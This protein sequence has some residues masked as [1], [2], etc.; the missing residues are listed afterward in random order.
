[1]LKVSGPRSIEFRQVDTVEIY[2]PS[3]R[4]RQDMVTTVLPCP[5]GLVTPTTLLS[6]LD[7]GTGK[8]EQ[9]EWAPFGLTWADGTVRFAR[10]TFPV[11]LAGGQQRQVAIGIGGGDAGTFTIPAAMGISIAYLAI[12]IEIEG[13]TMR[14][15]NPRELYSGNRTRMLRYRQRF[16]ASAGDLRRFWVQ[17]DIQLQ[18]GMRHAKMWLSFGNSYWKTNPANPRDPSEVPTTAFRPT[19]PIRVRVGPAIYT[20]W[21]WDHQAEWGMGRTIAGGMHQIVVADPSVHFDKRRANIPDGCSVVMFGSLHFVNPPFVSNSLEETTYLAEIDQ[22]VVGMCKGWIAA[23]LANPLFD[24]AVPPIPAWFPTEAAAEQ[25]AN[26]VGWAALQDTRTGYM[27]AFSDSHS[28]CNPQPG[29]SGDQHAFGRSLLW[30]EMRTKSVVRLLS[31]RRSEA[32]EAYRA[33]TFRE[34]DT[35]D[36]VTAA[37]HPKAYFWDCRPFQTADD[38]GGKTTPLG[39]DDYT[40]TEQSGTGGAFIYGHDRQHWAMSPT[41]MM[42]MV[43]GDWWM[44]ERL[45]D[46]CEQFLFIT[47]VNCGNPTI[48]G[49]D[50]GRAVD[51]VMHVGAFL[52]LL[53]A[54]DDVRVRLLERLALTRTYWQGQYPGIVMTSLYVTS[55]EIGKTNI[56]KYHPTGPFLYPWHD[57]MAAGGLMATY[58]MLGVA[59]A[60][61]LTIA[62]SISRYWALYATQDRIT[63][64]KQVLLCRH[65]FVSAPFLMATPGD[66]MVEYDTSNVEVARGTYVGEYHDNRSA[67]V[68]LR[69]CTAIFPGRNGATLTN[70][71]HA[72]MDNIIINKYKAQQSAQEMWWNNGQPL[73]TAELEIWDPEGSKKVFPPTTPPT[74]IYGAEPQF[75][76]VRWGD[77]ADFTL[78]ASAA[79]GYGKRW[80]TE[81]NDTAW[82]ARVN[83]MIPEIADL[84]ITGASWM[85]VQRNCKVAHAGVPNIFP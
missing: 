42:A 68:H 23:K 82:L 57:G 76:N 28:G 46:K 31:L 47:P 81:A 72:G 80:A 52:Y 12:E 56:G 78:W 60:D 53:T 36:V 9:C 48:D 27:F 50:A 17:A 19:Q 1:M 7:P 8:T 64:A 16:P 41:C 24:N 10:C 20:D 39:G 37:N 45:K 84:V 61:A 59:A 55:G 2:N 73:T 29:D 34:W 77:A 67:F 40:Y 21:K 79:L 26:A 6:V 13:V 32:W 65:N 4:A 49:W 14:L 54:R 44:M 83:A 5:Q 63:T 69:N 33:T 43:T 75:H 3:S 30:P 66:I 15:D 74:Y 51:R 18:S 11:R 38:L 58:N 35:C 70:L 71:T 25:E 62:K 85:D 22:P